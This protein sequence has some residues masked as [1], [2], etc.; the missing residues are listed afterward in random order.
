MEIKFE[1][2]DPL[3]WSDMSA[4]MI[5]SLEI[6]H[7]NRAEFAGCLHEEDLIIWEVSCCFH[8]FM[9]TLHITQEFF[10][11]NYIKTT[12]IGLFIVN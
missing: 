4:K 3:R 8:C 1:N 9:F 6:L 11:V 10:A 2:L 5:P 12:R 7:K